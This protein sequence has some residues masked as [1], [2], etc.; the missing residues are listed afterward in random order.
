MSEAI[1]KL[2]AILEAN[3]LTEYNSYIENKYGKIPTIE[4][5]FAAQ[6]NN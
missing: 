6:E 1:K 2:E 5:Y 3:K 4:E